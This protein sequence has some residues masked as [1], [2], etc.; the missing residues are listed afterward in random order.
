[1]LIGS[2][3]DYATVGTINASAVEDVCATAQ[4]GAEDLLVVDNPEPALAGEKKRRHGV[5]SEISVVWLADGSHVDHRVG[6]VACG[7][8]SRHW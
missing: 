7:G 6:V 3:D 1:V 5:D 2:D 8:V 4:V